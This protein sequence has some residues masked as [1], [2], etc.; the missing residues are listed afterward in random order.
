MK[1]LL[2]LV[3]ETARECLP[4]GWR[5]ETM[6]VV[7]AIIDDEDVI[8]YISKSLD[9]VAAYVQAWRDAKV[10]RDRVLREWVI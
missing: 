7:T 10:L 1:E 2:D 3:T 5:V 8:R 6:P 9:C 4:K